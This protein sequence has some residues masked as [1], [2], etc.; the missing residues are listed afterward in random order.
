[1][2][3]PAIE[4][5]LL[6]GSLIVAIGA[7]NAFVLRQGLARRHVFPIATFC[8]LADALLIAAGVGGLGSLV[9]AM[10]RLLFIV[11]LAGAAF[12]TVYGAMAIRRA[13]QI[14][15]LSV[16]GAAESRLGPALATVAALT[17]LNP[18][19]YLDTVV[20]L[21]SLSARHAGEARLAFGLGAMM[22]SCVWFYA[23][24]YGAR[25][26]APLFARPI[27][28]QILDIVIGLVM[29]S[30]AASLLWQAFG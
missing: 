2:L 14:E 9:Q 8:F 10:P 24:G 26:L 19:V 28:W 3:Q 13:S 21:G 22:A 7:Q 25:L 30:I 27:A 16:V 29:F 20:L 5:F 6:G 23:L 4:G 18:H 11:T 15:G 1:M 17:F 12:L